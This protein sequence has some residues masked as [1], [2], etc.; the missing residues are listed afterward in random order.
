MLENT[1]HPREII[2]NHNQID[3][4]EYTY[5]ELTQ[6]YTHTVLIN[7]K[8]NEANSI[9]ALN[10]F[11]RNSN[12]EKYFIRI[13]YTKFITKMLLTVIII[14]ITHSVGFLTYIHE[15]IGH[16]FL[17]GSTITTPR[18]RYNFNYPSIY[19][20][21]DTFDNFMLMDKNFE[22]YMKFFFGLYSSKIHNNSYDGNAGKA[23]PLL[24]L[25]NYTD[26]YYKW[27]F[28]QS[29]AFYHI[30][31]IIPNYMLAVL[32]GFISIQISNHKN[33]LIWVYTLLISSYIYCIRLY[34]FLKDIYFTNTPNINHDILQWAKYLSIHNNQNANMIKN[35][36]ILYIISTYPLII[37]NSKL[38]YMIYKYDFITDKYAFYKIITDSLYNNI[39]FDYISRIPRKKYESWLKMYLNDTSYPIYKNI[40]IYMYNN[41]F[42][43]L[44]FLKQ[45]EK[46]ICFMSERPYLKKIRFLRYS[47]CIAIITIPWYN[48]YS[49][50]NKTYFVSYLLPGILVIINIFEKFIIYHNKP[51][52]NL[53]STDV[54]IL[55][56]IEIIS[57]FYIIYNTIMYTIYFTISNVLNL[58]GNNYLLIILLLNLI[59][60]LIV[61][62]KLSRYNRFIVD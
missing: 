22:N 56:L 44:D 34:S 4:C 17:G 6:I 48:A 47:L 32:L 9:R 24:N 39:L 8:F 49:Y 60:N 45:N 10:N 62:Y 59:D 61:Y 23:Y 28:E 37:L 18:N 55:T 42:S 5:D 36:T 16:L 38:S 53:L 14:H 33:N 27:G 26:I 1:S 57:N 21:I 3:L 50:T 43:K 29:T 20:Q 51:N 11:R 30:T 12:G 2:L 35:I 41:I 40:Y 52:I 7:N 13:N 31:G 15:T 54:K 19:Y 58:F 25:N 46:A